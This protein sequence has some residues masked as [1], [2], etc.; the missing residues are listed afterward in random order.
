[1]SYVIR[2]LLAIMKAILQQPRAFGRTIEMSPEFC[3]GFSMDD[4]LV[5]STTRNGEEDFSSNPLWSYFSTH[6]TGPGI[7][8]WT[9]Y[10][11]A[12]HRHFSQF[13]GQPV[14][15]LEIG[16]YSGGSLPMWRSYLGDECR[17]IGVDIEPACKSYQ[18]E[19]IQIFIGDQQDRAFWSRVRAAAPE[20]NIAIDDGGHT[21]EQQM[22]TLEELLPHMPPGSV[23]VCEDIHGVS[24][25]FAAFA[26]AMV[27]RLNATS[28]RL[29]G[30]F[31]FTPTSLQRALHSI[32]FYPYLCVIEKHRYSPKTIMAPK[33]GT[34]WQ[35]FL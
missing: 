11:E 5:Q 9:H 27:H 7:W 20:I 16:I 2:R 19:G 22:V 17:V 28:G 35:P 15:L 18:S 31:G 10:F 13:R 4:R 30:V 32:H 12:Y 24:N 14:T 34:E 3:R 33:H 8:K 26:T 6:K 23:Y 21:P 1:M 29:D 25:H